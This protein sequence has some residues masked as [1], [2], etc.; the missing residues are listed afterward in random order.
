MLALTATATPAVVEDILSQLQLRSPRV[1]R[2]SFN[3]PNVVYDVVCVGVAEQAHGSLFADLSLRLAAIR[4]QRR[5]RSVSLVAGIVYCHKRDDCDAFAE[6]LSAAG[7]R[8]AA[9]HSTTKKRDQVLADWTA[10]K[11]DIAVATIA[12]GMGIDKADVRFVVHLN[13][14]KSLEAFY[15]ESGRAGRDGKPSWSILYVAKDDLDMQRFLIS[16]DGGR[17]A[18]YDDDGQTVGGVQTSAEA[19]ARQQRQLKAL[20]EVVKYTQPKCRRATLLAHF[21]E[22]LA[23]GGAAGNN[24]GAPCCDYCTAPAKVKKE[25]AT[26]QRLDTD[27]GTGASSFMSAFGGGKTVS[28]TSGFVRLSEFVGAQQRRRRHRRVLRRGPGQAE[29]RRS[30]QGARQ[31]GGTRS[32]RER[33]ERIEH[34]RRRDSDSRAPAPVRHRRGARRRLSRAARRC[35]PAVVGGASDGGF[36]SA[37]RLMRDTAGPLYKA[38]STPRAVRQFRRRSADQARSRCRSRAR[39]NELATVQ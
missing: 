29:A 1:F 4:E 6:R 25:F 14:S 2:Q 37:L 18:E 3:R 13:V 21:G 35:V 39:R 27:A 26:Q 28:T 30:L 9:Y 7:L 22:V 32:G 10:G 11:I 33:V 17:V 24:G 36:S 23:A 34:H 16:K 19:Q 8:A 31:V 15:Q 12:F 5:Q 20:D 38:S